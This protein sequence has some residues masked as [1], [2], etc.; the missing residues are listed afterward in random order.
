MNLSKLIFPAVLLFAL[1]SCQEKNQGPDPRLQQP[2]HFK[3]VLE[4]HGDWKQWVDAKSLSFAMVHET[5]LEWENH[6]IDLRDG[7]VRIDADLFQAGNDGEQVWI[8]P[9]RQSFPGNS[10]RFYQNLYS[11]FLRIPYTLTDTLVT[12][13]PLDN[14][15]FNGISYPTL[16]AKVKDGKLLG[17]SNRYELLI[18]PTTG[19]LAWVLFAVT[20]YDKGNQVQEALK[21]E[22]YRDAGGLIFPRVITGY[23]IENDSSKKIRYQTSFSDVF[24]VKDKLD[25]DLFE[26]PKGAVKSN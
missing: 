24:L 16:E 19:Q 5:T 26:M 14:R 17:P 9:N 18:D 8:S 20:F 2:D 15:V 10:V 3:K 13:T 11:T 1:F 22:D 25:S 21:Y 6:Y 4:A 7:R 23:Q 12:I